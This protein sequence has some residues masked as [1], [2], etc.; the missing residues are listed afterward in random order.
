MDDHCQIA[1]IRTIWEMLKH[2]RTTTSSRKH[3]G[4]RNVFREKNAQA[5]KIGMEYTCRKYDER[6]ERRKRNKEEIVERRKKHNYAAV[7]DMQ[8]GEDE[9]GLTNGKGGGERGGEKGLKN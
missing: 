7:V 4:N 2:Q 8:E 6:R 5:G 1:V 3:S 9:E